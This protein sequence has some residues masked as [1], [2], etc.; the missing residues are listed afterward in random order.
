MMVKLKGDDLQF[1]KINY[2]FRNENQLVG[3]RIFCEGYSVVFH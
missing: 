1:I 3:K 2:C